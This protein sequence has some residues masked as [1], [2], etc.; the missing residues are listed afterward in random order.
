MNLVTFITG[1]Q[2][3]ADY[4]SRYLGLSIHHHPLD[5]EEIQSLDLKP[6]VEHKTKQAYQ[7][8]QS[9]VLVEDVSLE[10]CALGRLPGPLIKWFLQEMDMVAI[11]ALLK[12]HDRSAI[13][14]SLFGYY[15]G[16]ELRLFAGSLRGSIPWRPSG[17]KGFG[18]WDPIFIPAGYS[19]TRAEL[20][21][22]DDRKTY[23][24]LKPLAKLKSFL[25]DLQQSDV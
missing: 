4:L 25:E 8:I 24:Q 10:F 18:G 1:N 19:T 3:K 22:E 2:A 17:V 20:S 14:R 5:L 15:D 6:I 11:C 7:I 12:G 9:P 16:H 13:A 23:L 21:E